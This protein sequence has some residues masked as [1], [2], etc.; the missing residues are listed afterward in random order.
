MPAQAWITTRPKGR[1]NRL[2]ENVSVRVL[3]VDDNEVFRRPLQ[4][5]LEAA[6]YE[7]VA[8]PSGEDALDVLDRSTVDLVLT[9]RRLPE[10]DGVYLT[11]RIKA[12]RPTLA[13]VVMTAYGTIESAVEARRY[14]ADDYIEK[15]FEI[16]DL[17]LVLHR[18]LGQQ[19][20]PAGA[21]SS[22]LPWPT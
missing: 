21:E 14:G 4:R 1:K 13:I 8:V 17:L 2:E 18:A 12:M 15:P 10:M 5:T 20:A 16:P 7:V 19:Q 6:G 3:V 22:G 11:R 9:D